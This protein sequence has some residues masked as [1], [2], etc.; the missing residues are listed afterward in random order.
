MEKNNS[1]L[2]I[3]EKWCDAN[4]SMG[5]TNNYHNLFS[6]FKNK[7]P[8]NKYNIIHIDEYA[9]HKKKK[10]DD[11]LVKY[12]EDNKPN[13]IVFSLLGKSHLNPEFDTIAKLRSMGSKVIIMWPDVF[14]SWG[15]GE[16]RQLNEMSAVDL[17][18]CWGNEK[19]I[20]ESIDNLIWLWAPQDETLY[21]PTDEKKIDVSFLGSIRYIERQD[22]LKYLIINGVEILIDGGQREK[23]LTPSKY[24]QLMRNSKISL[25]FPAGPDGADQCKGRV[26]EILASKSLLFERKNNQTKHFLNPSEHYVEYDDKDDLI[27]K[28]KYFLDN[29]EE[30]CYIIENG[31]KKYKESYSSD[32]FWENIFKRLK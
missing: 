14:P 5:L 1:L 27:K 7:Y 25:N 15:I 3:T 18:V 26:W 16:I 31:F 22:Y 29:D 21:Y 28:I 23:G 17:H 19:N 9:L 4:P 12:V 11:F 32:I 13:Y 2:F 20:E 10:I 8:R 24:A 30:R 6:T